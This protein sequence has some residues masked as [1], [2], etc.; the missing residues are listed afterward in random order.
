[1]TMIC[2]KSYPISFEQFGKRIAG[3]VHAPIAE[4]DEQQL[5]SRRASLRQSRADFI[6][7]ASN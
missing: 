7:P 4:F 3:I 5:V 6:L 1:M 2:G